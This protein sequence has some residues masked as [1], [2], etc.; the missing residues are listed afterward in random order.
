VG[1]AWAGLEVRPTERLGKGLFVKRRFPEGA[2]V[3]TV[4]GTVWASYYDPDFTDGPASYAIGHGVWIEPHA[5][6][7][8]RFVNHSC[9]PTARMDGATKIAALR[10]IE[11]REELTI[12]YAMTEEDPYWSLACRCGKPSCRGTIT[13]G[14][15]F[16][17]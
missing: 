3:C 9:E 16:S 15:D 14:L 8:A 11:P 13:A 1:P 10:D 12:D 4:E 7:P 6:N 17:K 5:D 2:L